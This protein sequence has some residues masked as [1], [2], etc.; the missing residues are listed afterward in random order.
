MDDF[1]AR[2]D[3][4]D[5]VP[6]SRSIGCGRARC[7][8]QFTGVPA[9]ALVVFCALAIGAFHL[10]H[11]SENYIYADD[12]LRFA[13]YVDRAPT[14]IVHHLMLVVLHGVARVLAPVAPDIPGTIALFR[15]Y[16]AATSALA[17]SMVGLL[18]L[19]WFGSAGAAL[20]ALLSVAFTYG[21]WSYSIVTDLYVPAVAFLLLAVYLAERART[22]GRPNVDI[23]LASIALLVASLN[24]QAHAI[25]VVPITLLLLFDRSGSILPAKRRRIALRFLLATGLLGLICYQAAFEFSG[26]PGFLAFI[27]G[28]CGTFKML[29]YD[30]L[31]PLTPLYAVLGILRAIFY[32][33]IALGIDPIFELAQRAFPLKVLADDRYLVRIYPAAAIAVIGSVIAALALLI[34]VAIARVFRLMRLGPARPP[35]YRMVLYWTVMQSAMFCCWEPTSNEFWIWMMPALGLLVA[36]PMFVHG[37]RRARR[38]H[39]MSVIALFLVNLA[40]ISRY[41]SAENCIYSINKSYSSLVGPNDL[42][43]MA[44]FYQTSSIDQVRMPGVRRF[45]LVDGTCVDRD[46]RLF[47]MIDTV[48]IRGGSIFLDPMLAM[49]DRAE[50]AMRKWYRPGA[51]GVDRDLIELEGYCSDNAIPLY[52]IGRKGGEVVP[53]MKRKFGGYLRWI[54]PDRGSAAWGGPDRFHSGPGR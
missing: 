35:G 50:L 40:V 3:C 34:G 49:P 4:A 20:M 31:Q 13:L 5:S 52:G 36:G 51:R 12:S 47:A 41:W 18:T 14:I 33:E 2:H 45:E 39:M 23:V 9:R 28:Y 54:D 8:R 11:G 24:H 25:A 21:F 26:S 10:L 17:L 6:D 27:C 22:S 37:S 46:A 19:R 32:P 16:V 43:L 30:S 7:R 42:V 1:V 48:R 29:P 44:N 53:F 38:I 15:L